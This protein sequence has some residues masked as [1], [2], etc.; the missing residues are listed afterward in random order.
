MGL[1]VQASALGVSI[2]VDTIYDWKAWDVVSCIPV[3]SL[4]LR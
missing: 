4:Y 1:H 3:I 2:A